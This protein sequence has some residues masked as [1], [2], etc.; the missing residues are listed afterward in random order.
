MRPPESDMSETAQQYIERLLSYV[1]GKE[2]HAVLAATAGKLEGL[3]AGVSAADLRR[4][5]APN[6]WSVGEI[7][8]HLADAEVVGAFRMRLILGAPGTPIVAYD[9]DDWAK[10]GHYDKRDLQKSLEQFR[11]VREM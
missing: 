6:K 1:E 10:S 11:V 9:Q 2:P 8:A 3:I 4:R 5:P 7:L